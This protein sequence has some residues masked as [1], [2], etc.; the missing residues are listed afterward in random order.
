MAVLRK[1]FGGWGVRV[2]YFTQ[3]LVGMGVGLGLLALWVEWVGIP[4]ELAVLLNFV[5]MGA[6]SC[7]VV[8]RWV[9]DGDPAT[10]VRGFVRKFVGYQ[11][12]ML[13][14]KGVNYVIFVALLRVN[15][16]Y[17][18][19]WVAGAGVSFV[20]SLALNRLVWAHEQPA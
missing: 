2:R 15:I 9:F 6:V 14:S 16:W 13:T 7:G 19:A 18:L 3:A 17:P 11:A 20:L 4:P 10:T 12:S 5:L 8:D 1:W